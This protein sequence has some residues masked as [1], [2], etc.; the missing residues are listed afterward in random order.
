MYQQIEEPITANSARVVA[1]S[2]RSREGFSK[3]VYAQLAL[4]AAAILALYFPI[5]SYLA[6]QWYSDENYSHGFLV[7]PFSAYLIWRN[8]EKLKTIDSRPTWVGALIIL[9][10]IGIL[11]VGQIGADLFLSRVSLIGVIV[12]TILFLSGRPLL[13]ETAFPIFFLL[14]MIPLPTFLYN[15][16]VFPLQLMASKLATSLLEFI[17]VVPV[18]REG[19]LLILPNYTLQVVEACSGIRSLTSLLALGLAYGYLIE[20]SNIIRIVLVMSMVP[21]AIVS[22]AV[23]VMGTALLTNYFGIQMAEGFLHAFSGWVIFLVSMVL[24]IAIHGALVGTRKWMLARR[25]A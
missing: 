4:L 1:N 11:F 14:L 5:L 6:T 22:N 9:L 24:L 20:R 21:V 2:Q 12:G 8:R 19:N 7:V 18:L 16:I 3:Q 10:S 23:R 15:Q 25:S 13:K 17:N